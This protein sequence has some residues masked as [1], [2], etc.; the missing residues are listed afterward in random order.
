[1][2]TFSFCNNTN[3]CSHPPLQ[4]CINAGVFVCGFFSYNICIVFQAALLRI[5]HA[6]QN[7]IK[8]KRPKK[9]PHWK[10]PKHSKQPCSLPE[11]VGAGE[12]C[13]CPLWFLSK[14]PLMFKFVGCHDPSLEILVFIILRGILML[15][16]NGVCG[17]TSSPSRDYNY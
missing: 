11:A 5:A 6:S 15:Q 13:Y 1:M 2:K 9:A 16:I 8:G 14:W 7:Q 4:S 12:H 17:V 10:N 3:S